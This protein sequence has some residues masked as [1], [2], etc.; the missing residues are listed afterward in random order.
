[1]IIEWHEHTLPIF[2]WLRV[3]TV[4]INYKPLVSCVRHTTDRYPATLIIFFYLFMANS[5]IHTYNT[6]QSSDI[7]ISYSHTNIIHLNIV[8]YGAKI[9]NSID[10]SL[11]NCGT[12][13]NFKRAY[14]T[15]LI[16]TR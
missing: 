2:N 1:M 8:I 7:H 15:H 4:L 6:R 5:D 13:L 16:V 11:K 14:K 10:D 9:W 3:L 12:L